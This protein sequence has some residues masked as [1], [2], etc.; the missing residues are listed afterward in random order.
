M[1]GNGSLMTYTEYEKVLD[2]KGERLFL[3]ISQKKRLK[4]FYLE[5]LRRRQQQ[6]G[7]AP[8]SGAEQ[9]GEAGQLH[10]PRL[11]R[12]AQQGGRILCR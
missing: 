3:R 12:A 10:Q 2:P 1:A 6:G 8:E 9:Q 7:A 4:Y 5:T 11:P